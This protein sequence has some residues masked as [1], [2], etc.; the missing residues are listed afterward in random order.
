MRRKR[1][2]ACLVVQE[3]WEVEG[4]IRTRCLSVFDSRVAEFGIIVDV[5]ECTGTAAIAEV[6]E[7]DAGLLVELFDGCGGGFA[8]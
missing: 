8:E 3:S 4:M 6:V 2:S 1:L 7:E 5:D